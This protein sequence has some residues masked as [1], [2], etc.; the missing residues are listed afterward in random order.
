MSEDEQD[1]ENS[2]CQSFACELSATTL[3]GRKERQIAHLRMRQLVCRSHPA[4]LNCA[5]KYVVFFSVTVK[6]IQCSLPLQAL[7]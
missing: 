4:E 1:T 2:H 6:E 7:L 5:F 3:G